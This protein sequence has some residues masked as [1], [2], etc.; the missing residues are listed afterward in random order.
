MRRRV[1]HAGR[2]TMVDV[3]TGR[4]AA[5]VALERVVAPL[6]ARSTLAC[7]VSRHQLSKSISFDT[8][9]KLLSAAPEGGRCVFLGANVEGLVISLS[10]AHADAPRKRKRCAPT[11]AD[12]VVQRLSGSKRKHG[13]L[14]EE[15]VQRAV[16]KVR[17]SL[18]GEHG[19][20]L[21]RAQAALT[22]LLASVRGSEGETCIESYGLHAGETASSPK[23][24]MAVRFSPGVA[25]PLADIRNALGKSCVDGMITSSH[26]ADTQS[27][28]LPLSESGLVACAAGAVSV[29]MH[30]TVC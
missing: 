14:E 12:R 29:T 9:M 10:F 25:L 13:T 17:T 30:A 23:L 22:A 1:A 18:G 5:H 27:R 15:E 7:G 8:V 19:E 28:T 3:E 16:D 24:V 4:A 20:Q 21:A 2:I 26:D 6:H 11:L